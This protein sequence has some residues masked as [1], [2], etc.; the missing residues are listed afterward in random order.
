MATLV[1]DRWVER[2]PRR[3]EV[4]AQLLRET[5]LLPWLA[6]QLPLQVP[7]PRVA[8]ENPLVVRHALIPG[9]AIETPC[10]EQGFLIGRFLR[11]LHDC[12]ANFPP[13]PSSTAISV[14]STFWSPPAASPA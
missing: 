1:D 6:A 13:I 3:P 2:R 10:A 12:P 5:R 14:P 11:A 9:S 7:V 4:A 8:G